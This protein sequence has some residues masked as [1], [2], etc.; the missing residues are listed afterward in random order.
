MHPIMRY[1][2]AA[3][4][5]AAL[6]LAVFP[7]AAEAHERRQVGPFVV[8]V[9]FEVEPTF[10]EEENAALIQVFRADGQPVEGVEKTLKV[11]IGIGGA[12]RTFDLKPRLRQPGTYVAE[13]IPTKTGSYTFRFFGAIEGQNVNERFESG[14]N[15]FD[16]VVSKADLQFPTKVPSNGELAAQLQQNRPSEG[17]PGAAAEDVRRALDRAD[18][19]R[20]TGIIVG[21]IGIVLGV[22]GLVVGV[23]SLMA[24]GGR[25]SATPG[26]PEPI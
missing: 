17:A 9:G 3:T 12:G 23:Y 15:R 25:G 13:F 16:D 2:L 18:S 22:A 10:V 14:P 5:L 20:V 1:L 21:T 24:R 19:A 11:E 6:A 4:A 7:S 26:E 8:V